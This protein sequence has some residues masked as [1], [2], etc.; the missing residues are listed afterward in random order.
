MHK[1]NGR[2]F[3]LRIATTPIL[4]Y[5]GALK[6]KWRGLL[7][8]SCISQ[9]VTL[10]GPNAQGKRRRSTEGAQGTNK[11]H[12]F[13]IFMALVGVRLTAQLGTRTEPSWRPSYEWN[14]G[15]HRGADD[16]CDRCRL[17]NS[18]VDPIP[19]LIV[20]GVVVVDDL[21]NEDC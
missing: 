12:A 10:D 8:W 6:L 7:H 9:G 18:S 5:V 21:C 14:D 16:Q 15:V 13:G 1:A 17:G 11:G 4:V 2:A 19:P 20:P 3:Q